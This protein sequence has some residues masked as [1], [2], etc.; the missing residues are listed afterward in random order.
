[1]MEGSSRAWNPHLESSSLAFAL[2]LWDCVE[3]LPSPGP[4]PRPVAKDRV[5]SQ[6]TLSLAAFDHCNMDT[7]TSIVKM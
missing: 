6:P 3:T 2:C 5:L 1:M 4:G 7:S